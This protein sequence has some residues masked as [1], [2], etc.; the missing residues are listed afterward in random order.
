[1]NWS[2]YSYLAGV[3]VL[4]VI[5]LGVIW[6]LMPRLLRKS[7]VVTIPET[8]VLCLTVALGLVT[9]Y[10]NYYRGTLSFAYLDVGNDTIE[11]YVPYYSNM[12]DAIR[13]GT[14]GAWNHEYG[15]GVSFMS[16]QSWTLDPFN[17]VFVPLALL[18]GNARIPLAL[19]FVQS[20]KVLVVAL[21]FDHLLAYYCQTPLSRVLGS[22]LCCFSGYLMLWGQHYWLGTV[23]VMATVMP[24]LL[25]RLMERSTAGRFAALAVGTALCIVSSVYSGFMVMLFA[26]AYALLRVAFVCKGGVKG[27]LGLFGRLTLPVVCGILIS[28]VAVVPYATLMLGESTRVVGSQNGSALSRAVTYLGTFVPLRWIP[29]ILSRTLG[30]GLVSYGQPIS[31][32]IMP[33]TQGFSYVNV[34]EIITLGL[35]GAAFVLLSQFAA[36]V[37]AQTDKRAKVLVLVATALI[38]LYCFNFFLPAFSNAL[39]APKYR[40]SFAVV[41]PACIAMAV[42]FDRR[43]VTRTVARL[44]LLAS[45]ALSLGIIVWSLV[46]TIDGRLA[47]L[48]YLLA[49][50]ATTALLWQLS[51]GSVPVIQ[52][53][54]AGAGTDGS[55][56]EKGPEGGVAPHGNHAAHESG[57]TFVQKSLVYCLC[58]MA[59]VST[60]IADGFFSTNNR[61]ICTSDNMPGASQD[62]HGEDTMAALKWLE[63]N[64]KTFWRAEKLYSDWTWLNDSLFQHYRGI[65]SYNSTL[66]GD[67]EEFYQQLWPEALA[68]DTAYQAYGNNPAQPALLRLLGVKYLL[69]HEPLS[70]DWCR[71]LNRFGQVYV[72]R[73][74]QADSILTLRSGVLTEEEVAQLDAA[75]RRE[76]LAASVIV[77]NDDAQTYEVANPTMLTLDDLSALDLSWMRFEDW[78]MGE[79]GLPAMVPASQAQVSCVDGKVLKGTLFANV[80]SV[81]C[82]SVP[83]VS[84]WTVLV[85]GQKVAMTRANY[86]FIG[87]AVPAGVHQVEARYTAPNL[88]LGTAISCAGLVGVLVGCV[89]IARRQ[90]R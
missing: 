49:L 9:I 62:G 3:G 39:V 68:G 10:F 24:L 21:V 14:L 54:A 38:L 31:D 57:T 76:M 86:G 78:E 42:G 23:F 82:L 72:Y 64:D 69:S 85:D 53:A 29:M 65:S 79:D 33:P 12:V 58:C 17:L 83:H 35:S 77:P 7:E 45:T 88:S 20:L 80:D 89:F 61:S 16:Y 44:P 41:I 87:F 51:D 43:V 59:I 1:M 8:V 75:G 37:A 34:Y 25:E 36:W 26:T 19:V 55:I 50:C 74:M 30:N 70:W 28:C 48:W 66:D 27:F 11:Q 2:L 18:L 47:C 84:G 67:I 73:N 5:T 90:T 6:R 63:E 81:A 46:N 4:C 60:S 32:T 22:L 40:S 52:K 15:L 71:E 13:S 56:Q